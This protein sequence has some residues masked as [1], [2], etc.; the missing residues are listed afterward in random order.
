MKE[1][2]DFRSDTVTQ[3]TNKM[4][5]AMFTAVVGDDVSQEDPTINKLEELAAQK[6]GKEA[7]LFVPT[8]TFGNQLALLTHCKRG[9]EIILHDSSHIIQSEVG[10]ASVIAGVQ[11]RT[12]QTKKQYLSW[13]SIKKYIRPSD[14]LHDPNTGLVIVQNSL[15]NGDVM[16]LD[17]MRKIKIGLMES[18]I[19]VHLDGARIFN[20]ATYLKVDAVEI[21]QYADSVMFCLSKG[22]AAP[23]GSVLV[24]TKEFIAKARRMRK[25]M[26]GGMRQA[27]FL[28]AAGIIAIEKMTK[29]LD[30]DHKNA[31]L[32]AKTL[33]EYD[34]FEVDLKLIK[35]NM[36][37]FKI[38]AEEGKAQKF[39]NFLLEN[40]VKVYPPRNGE[41]RFVTHKDI[42][43]GDIYQFQEILKKAVEHI[44]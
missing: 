2:I 29:R 17:E 32:L 24:G 20:A 12:I 1:V 21:A 11:T 30:Q 41:M 10:A 31:R 42:A 5:K 25:L 43:K 14:E 39:A 40:N 33:L 23:V 7:G 38:N 16:P 4:R 28:A 22:L 26:G 13:K 35:T 18:E 8:G 15:T 44:S 37:F 34:I 19:P 3:P 6:M 27:G 36:F 9:Q